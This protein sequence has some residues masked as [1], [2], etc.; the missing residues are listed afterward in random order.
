MK[1]R[2]R[3]K[4]NHKK[5][6]Q[7]LQDTD[8]KASEKDDHTFAQFGF[9]NV[10]GRHELELRNK[11]LLKIQYTI[12]IFCNKNIVKRLWTRDES[13]AVKGNG[14][15]T[16]TTKKDYVKDSGEVWFDEQSISKM[17]ALKNPAQVQSY[18]W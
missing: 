14:G 9:W 12:D 18:I 5:L 7:F 16:K 4:E 13:M 8:N 2:P 6:I 3:K 11:L 15:S 10:G 1:N 17:F